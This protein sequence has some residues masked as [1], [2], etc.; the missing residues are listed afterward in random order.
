VEDQAF[1]RLASQVSQG[2]AILFTGAG[3]SL[4]A[5]SRAGDPLPSVGA[6]TRELWTVAFPGEE[7][8]GSV[9]QDTFDAALMQARRATIE[10][11]QRR[12]AVDPRAIPAYYERWF[13]MPWYRIYTLNV[14]DL[15]D[16]ANI[17]FDLPRPLR[18]ISALHEPFVAD[19]ARLQVVHLNGRLG[20]IPDVTFA[21]RQYAERLSSPDPWYANLARELTGR[22]VVYV[23]TTLDEPPL[24]Q[25]V[26]ARGTRP[27]RGRE[28]RPGSYMVS[29]NV[30]R[31]RAVAL[32][33]YNV[34]WITSTAQEFA[35]DVLSRL[36]TAAEDGLRTLSRAATQEDRALQRVAELTADSVGDEREFLLGREPRWSDLTEGFAIE[37]TFDADVVRIAS[38]DVRLLVITGTAGSGKSTS[39]MRLVLALA[40]EGRKV[41]RL[42]LDALLRAQR[43]RRAVEAEQPHVL[44]IDDLERLGS[45]APGVLRDLRDALPD[46]LIVA[47]LR[48]ARYDA[49]G[50]ADLVAEDAAAREAVAP[51][52]ADDD[53]DALLDT[54]DRANRL[55]TLK[56]RTR[57]EQRNVFVSKCG[58][59]LLVALIEATS[60]QRFDEKVES[61]CRELEGDYP[62]SAVCGHLRADSGMDFAL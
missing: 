35:D 44:F 18:P 13:A 54:L 4:D 26:E 40:A 52:L 25:Y 8:D 56:G 42:N 16:A 60:G 39:A 3:F 50:I 23:G 12:L 41:V 59:Q 5:L 19:E 27:S 46:L 6:L 51:S 43:I 32:R 31:A 45:S 30:P 9:L 37:R 17:A 48:S 15:P 33:Q 10:L 7:Y 38:E 55:G 1:Q 11:L 20:D 53:I 34:D 58:R 21:G 24:W 57:L 62:S 49:L 14:D 29:P 22:P 28:L 2:R 47:A 61:E 36:D